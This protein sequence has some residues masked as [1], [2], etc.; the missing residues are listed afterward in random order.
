MADPSN[1]YAIDDIKFLTGYNVEPVVASEDAIER[2]DRALLR[3][4]ARRSTR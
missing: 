3:Q 1:I 2:G 4:G